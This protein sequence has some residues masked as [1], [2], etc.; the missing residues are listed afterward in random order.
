LPSVLHRRAWV[1]LY[2][3]G[4]LLSYSST[5]DFFS[6]SP[7]HMNPRQ[8]DRSSRCEPVPEIGATK[9]SIEGAPFH[10]KHFIVRGAT[11]NEAVNN[12]TATIRGC[13]NCILF[14]SRKIAGQ[15]NC[16][17]SDKSCVL[18]PHL[19]RGPQSQAQR[20]RVPTSR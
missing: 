5:Q 3:T 12:A 20:Q 15:C 16:V 11:D 19:I 14:R 8:R 17:R 4:S 10:W 6:T 7:Q 13:E 1:L 18:I 2:F 9:M